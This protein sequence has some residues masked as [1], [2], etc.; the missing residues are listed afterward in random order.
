MNVDWVYVPH[1]DKD[2]I[3]WDVLMANM[4]YVHI[5]LLAANFFA[6]EP[7]ILAWERVII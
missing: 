6:L 3:C 5:V 2:A 4:G 1:L 7:L